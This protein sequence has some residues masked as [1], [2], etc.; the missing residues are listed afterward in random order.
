[1][2]YVV[3][4]PVFDAVTKNRVGWARVYVATEERAQELVAQKPT[5][6]YREVATEA[7]P[8]HARANMERA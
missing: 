2:A 1:M 3:E 5:A 4:S 6:R 7:M 8:S